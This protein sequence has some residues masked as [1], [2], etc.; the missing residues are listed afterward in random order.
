MGVLS[1]L[2]KRSPV[3][4]APVEHRGSGLPLPQTVLVPQ[5]QSTDARAGLATVAA[6]MNLYELCMSMATVSP[7]VLTPEQMALIGRELTADGN[8]VFL[9]DMT[10]GET[11]L[12]HALE[13]SII[14]TANPSTWR[15]NL[16]IP[17]PSH[18]ES[19]RALGA[20]VLHFRR[21]VDTRRPW[22]GR[23][24]WDG[25]SITLAGLSTLARNLAREVSLQTEY[26]SQIGS[27]G[28]GGG[29]DPQEMTGR[30]IHTAQ[31]GQITTSGMPV[32]KQFGWLRKGPEPHEGQLRMMAELQPA[33]ASAAGIPPILLSGQP[34]Q[35]ASI[36]ESVRSFLTLSLNPL[37][38]L[39]ASE[40]RR[41]LEIDVS[42]SFERLFASDVQGRARAFA[43]LTKGG[44][45]V[46][47]ASR[48]CGFDDA[49]G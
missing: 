44:M 17:G 28:Y 29:R 8:S 13:H 47:A 24:L 31:G 30:A 4:I 12:T 48:A 35:G 6:C 27:D 34:I 39:I 26:V 38:R 3:E 25:A 33:I 2:R 18:T 42:I 11:H 37:G 10:G 9:I 20:E 7:D 46:E 36:R 21:G 19:Y 45:S 41:K 22:R 15:Y 40:L 1:R 5:F 32:S 43:A 23:G 14:G 16:T 49:G